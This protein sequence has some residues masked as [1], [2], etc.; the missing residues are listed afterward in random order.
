[1]F[2]QLINLVDDELDRLNISIQKTSGGRFAIIL[3][4]TATENSTTELGDLLRN[5]LYVEGTKSE[6]SQHLVQHIAQYSEVLSKAFQFN[7][8]QS[9]SAIETAST[10]SKEESSVTE[11]ENSEEATVTD[12]LAP[13]ETSMPSLTDKWE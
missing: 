3:T 1:M 8:A 13:V 9:I 12:D 6:L 2:D 4:G 5:N 11:T 10:S 7:T